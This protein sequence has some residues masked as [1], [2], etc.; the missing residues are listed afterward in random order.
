MPASVR[1][2]SDSSPLWARR[3]LLARQPRPHLSHQPYCRSPASLDP[4]PTT[5]RAQTA[6]YIRQLDYPL[7]VGLVFVALSSL[8]AQEA[9]KALDYCSF[10]SRFAWLKYCM[11]TVI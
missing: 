2:D 5:S 1:F 3:R 6:Q 10:G 7:D 9:A 4:S 11:F 8:T